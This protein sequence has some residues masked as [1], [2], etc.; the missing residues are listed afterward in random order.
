M[1]AVPWKKIRT[2]WLKGGT[3]YAKLAKKYGIKEQTIK[4]HASKEAWGNEKVLIED[5]VRTR[6]RARIVCV[7]EEQLIK[8]ATANGFLIDS[9]V[10]MAQQA[11]DQQKQILVDKN[12]TLRNA[13]SLSKAIQL[14][15]MN[16]R[17]LYRLPDMDME[18][19]KK[20]AAARKKE[21]KEKL[22]LDKAKWEAVQREKA[23]AA[24]G[25]NATMWKVELPE[26]MQ[27]LEGEIDG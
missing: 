19:R 18:L 12:G 9:L 13:E 11:T 5:E 16:Q 15:I 1:A 7:R 17:D 20:E 21:A 6:T 14:A 8:L 2:E 24:A 22:A 26:E 4:N 25:A 23:D 10:D 3:T 27:K